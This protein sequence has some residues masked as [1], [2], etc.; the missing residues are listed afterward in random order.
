VR[1][2]TEELTKKQKRVADALTDIESDGSLD[3][4]CN[5]YGIGRDVLYEWLGN[6][7][8]REYMDMVLNG[9]T[10]SAMTEV[11]RSLLNQCGEGNIQAIKLYFE[12][13]GKYKGEKSAIKTEAKSMVQIIDDIPRGK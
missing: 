2:I 3:D 10:F 12:L 6:E 13:N 9:K 7:K 1:I 8:F 5:E 4:V 11:W